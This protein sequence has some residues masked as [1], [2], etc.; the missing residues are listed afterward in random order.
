V[1][2]LI[3][4]LASVLLAASAPLETN[5]P[6]AAPR[7]NATATD[8]TDPVEQAFAKLLADD[9]AAQEEAD[10]WIKN[11]QA[12]AEKGAGLGGATLNLRL[13]QRFAEV[14]KAYENFLQL[15]PQHARARLAYGS[16]LGDTGKEEEAMVQWEKARELDPQNPAV[17]NNLANYYGEHG[18]VTNAF[19]FYAKAIEL[20]PQEALYYD[21]YATT[22]FL[23]RQ[24]ATNFFRISEQKVFDRAL[25]LYR[26][27]VKLDPDNFV[28]ATHWAETY[29]GIIPPRWKEALAAWQY[30]LKQARDDVEREGV[31]VHLARIELASG[32]P[33]EAKKYLAKITNSMYAAIRDRLARNVAS[34]A[35]SRLPG[36]TNSPAAAPAQRDPGRDVQPRVR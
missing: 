28:L 16:F 24:E 15:H 18:P 31:Y 34:P 21:N 11:N 19:A 22:V 26:Q 2:E 14:R 32:Q 30:A 7:G 36:A 9:D 13:E 20:N 3:V 27:A 29:Y 5:R 4:G 12:F 1:I 6:P 17:W 25:E 23:F 10:Q 33:D 8:A 35:N